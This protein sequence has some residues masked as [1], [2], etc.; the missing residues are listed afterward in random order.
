MGRNDCEHGEFVLP[1]AEYATFRQRIQQVAL[2][3]Q[4]QAFALTQECWKSLS[5]KE[6]TD[7][8]AYRE[9]VAKFLHHK[10]HPHE[11]YR[12]MRYSDGT[13]M[14]TVPRGEAMREAQNQMMRKVHR[15]GIPRRVLKSDMTFP[16]NRTTFFCDDS[17][18]IEFR[19]KDRTVEWDVPYDKNAVEDARN[20]QLGKAFFAQLDQVRWTH[21]TG[22]ALSGNDE[23]HRDET[24]YGGGGNYC[25]GAYGY[26]G[27]Q[28][29]PDRVQPFTNARGQQVDVQVSFGRSGMKA[30]IVTGPQGRAAAG[31]PTGGQFTASPRS[32]FTGVDL[33]RY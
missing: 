4:Q 22:G 13:L 11:P 24:E 19:P 31:Q 8:A 2:Q 30:K 6:R 9:A 20:S 5:R 1:S 14:E 21:G 23:Y 10:A 3:Q 29:H 26:L 18:S 32:T 28:N 16:T 15:G 27:A 25:T 17:C 12:P 33:G 7:P